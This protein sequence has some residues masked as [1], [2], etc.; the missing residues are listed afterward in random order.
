[1]SKPPGY[2]KLAVEERKR[3]RRMRKEARRIARRSST[4]PAPNEP[5]TFSFRDAGLSWVFA[6]TA[7]GAVY[8]F[9]L[10]VVTALVEAFVSRCGPTH[11]IQTQCKEMKESL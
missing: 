6:F 7:D 5:T 11:S 9:E 2:K 1:M 4:I 10:G 8:E 3:K